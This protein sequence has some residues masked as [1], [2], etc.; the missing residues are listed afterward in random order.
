MSDTGESTADAGSGRED[1]PSA[2]ELEDAAVSALRECEANSDTAIDG[3]PRGAVVDALQSEYDV[4]ED[5]A[6]QAILDSQMA[7]RAYLTHGPEQGKQAHVRA[8]DEPDPNEDPRDDIATSGSGGSGE[9]SSFASDDHPSPEDLDIPPEEVA[10]DPPEDER[11]PDEEGSDYI[12]DDDHP[13]REP[14]F[15]GMMSG[16]SIRLRGDEDEEWREPRSLY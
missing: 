5:A 16:E 2:D 11:Q 7:G 4:D 8:P 14:E 6:L 13:E 3:A 15:P 10:P 1:T 12:L 9:S